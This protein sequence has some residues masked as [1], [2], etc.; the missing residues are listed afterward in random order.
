MGAAVAGTPWEKRSAAYEAWAA[1]KDAANA[2]SETGSQ[3]KAL[4]AANTALREAQQGLVAA[5]SEGSEHWMALSTATGDFKA[6]VAKLQAAQVAA[7]STI[8][9]RQLAADAVKQALADIAGETFMQLSSFTV[10]FALQNTS[11][12]L[13]V[14]YDITVLGQQM[15]GN[16]AIDVNASPQQEMK[17]MLVDLMA[18]EALRAVNAVH[19]DIQPFM[20]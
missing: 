16:F 3:G 5:V 15:V 8:E 12:V 19:T 17:L 6:A 18:G 1:A 2:L 10:N 14:Y 20:V 11:V 9:A 4:E 7:K 13:Y